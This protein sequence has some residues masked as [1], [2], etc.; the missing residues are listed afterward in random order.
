[1][2]TATLFYIAL[3]LMLV[4]PLVLFNIKKFKKKEPGKSPRPN[5]FRILTVFALSVLIIVFMYSL[6]LFSYGY[7]AL[8]VGERY[9]NEFGRLRT[10]SVSREEF[11]ENTADLAAYDQQKYGDL[12]IFIASV[13]A[14]AASFSYQLSDEVLPKYFEN[15]PAIFK[16]VAKNESA[17]E[18]AETIYLFINGKTDADEAYLVL[19][20]RENYQW[21]VED[22]YPTT[23]EAIEY[24]KGANRFLRGDKVVKWFTVNRENNS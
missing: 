15:E 20:R 8:L 2:L 18:E 13:P 22:F 4:C 7:Q 23:Q 3:T 24:A 21:K 5:I 1:M 14:D 17:E 11:Y 19:M 12:V 9:M 10:G 6:C 16:E